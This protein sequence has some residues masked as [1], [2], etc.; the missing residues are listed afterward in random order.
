MRIP[1]LAKLNSANFIK[2]FNFL[3][4][5]PSKVCQAPKKCSVCG[6]YQL[7]PCLSTPSGG[8]GK[9]EVA[10]EYKNCIVNVCVFGNLPR[11]L[12]LSYTHFE[13]SLLSLL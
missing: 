9:F 1:S 8:V 4:V 3:W 12:D 5:V 7:H 6:P 11:I 10:R 2:N 13:K